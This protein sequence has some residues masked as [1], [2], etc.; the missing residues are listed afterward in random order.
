MDA[1]DADRD[2]D[3]SSEAGQ[4]KRLR[5]I[6]EMLAGILKSG[7]PYKSPGGIQDKVMMQVTGAD[8]SVKNVTST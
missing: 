1:N 5:M 4:V 6:V 3:T 8:G 7:N 2:L